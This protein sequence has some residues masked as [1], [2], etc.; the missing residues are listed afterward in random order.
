MSDCVCGSCAACTSGSGS[1]PLV[2]AD[3]IRF[4]HGAI[5]QRMLDLVTPTE[6]DGLRPLDR[7]GTRETDDPAIAL[8]D[9]FAASLHVLARNIG[10]VSDDGSIRRTQDR[11]TL[12]ELTR[13]L[14][15]EPR[16]AIAATTTLS[17]MVENLA[18]SPTRVRVPKGTNVASVPGQNEK[19][20]T[21]ETDLD[22]DARVELNE[23]RPV[24]GLVDQTIAAGSSK[25]TV[26]GTATTAKV[27]D[28]LLVC[29]ATN[30]QW[31]LGRITSVLRQP[32]PPPPAVPSTEL[33][34]GGAVFVTEVG[35]LATD[36]GVVIVLGQRAAPFGA[37]A[38]HKEIVGRLPNSSLPDLL[39]DTDW[40]FVPTPSKSDLVDLDAVY[41][42]AL[43]DR[44]IVLLRDGDEPLRLVRTVGG[45]TE[46]A[47]VDYALSSK[48]SRVKI[49]DSDF[50]T[51]GAKLDFTT[52]VRG[53]SVSIETGRDRL[54]QFPDTE[55]PLPATSDHL[56]VQGAIEVPAGR[57]VVLTG[58]RFG[59][60]GTVSEVAI[61]RSS[62]QSPV[63]G[64][65]TT[66][67]SFERPT[68][69]QY[70]STSL[71][72]LANCVAASHAESSVQGAETLGSGDAARLAQRFVLKRSPLAYLP[73]ANARGYA[74]AIDVDVGGRIY[75]ANPSIFG[76]PAED[77]SY[78]VNQIRGGKS[79]VQFNGRLPTSSFNVHALYRTGGGLAGNLDASRLSTIMTPVFGIRRA[80]NPIKTEGGSDPEAVEDVRLSAPQSVRALDRVVSLPDFEAFARGY[81]GVG[82]ALATELQMGM[83]NIVCL[84]IA[85]T[86]LVSPVDGSDL[87]G[88][89]RASLKD[90]A[91]PGRVIRIEGFDDV[92]AQVTVRLA[93]DPTTHRRSDVET[94][95]R[96][97]LADAFGPARRNF[98]EALTR[99]SVMATIQRVPGVLATTV[100]G[101]T[102]SLNEPEDEGRL[103][104]PVPY[105]DKSGTFH[106]AGL[107][108]IA[109]SGIS[110]EEMQ[111]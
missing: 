63:N 110:F 16:P 65:P 39:A 54:L 104:A 68:A 46:I 83:R 34:I 73:A 38:P 32:N 52:K 7:L 75:D 77:R 14:G 9:A 107:I 79:E 84:T 29:D 10:F 2:V 76:L 8:I 51:V 109:A 90:A 12:I 88:G 71:L 5:R 44:A 17:F 80:V 26:A 28:L 69:N 45:V 40:T 47:R 70:L 48:V 37:A 13:L 81:R 59:G 94:A 74:P 20:Q 15:Y 78:A 36:P 100:S 35:D 103:F 82:K 58:T 89:L 60:A 43:S 42:D 11:E 105:L 53:T 30:K 66:T 92:P 96:A 56:V 1:P 106:R 50:D 102:T 87:V 95:V 55:H 19:P 41:A 6:I 24:V 61:V 99:S 18:G 93:V 3:P 27:G 108:H 101:F 49:P 22:L 25:L 72:V 85:T 97:A 23:L 4:R 62:V 21:F 111:P 98:G 64:S 31:L 57:R 86:T 67:L 91:V 33:G